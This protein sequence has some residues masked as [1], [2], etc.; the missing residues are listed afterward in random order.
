MVAT[1]QPIWLLDRVERLRNGTEPCET[2]WDETLAAS[3][4]DV[5]AARARLEHGE[6]VSPDI[7]EYSGREG[8]SD[9]LVPW[10]HIRDVWGRIMEPLDSVSDPSRV[11]QAAFVL[12]KRPW[13]ARHAIRLLTPHMSADPRPRG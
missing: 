1:T 6:F 2:S 10:Q 12:R 13:P 7:G 4:R 9:V 8:Y 5:G 3:W 11:A